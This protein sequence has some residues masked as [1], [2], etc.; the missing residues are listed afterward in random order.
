MSDIQN[1]FTAYL[2]RAIHNGKCNYMQKINHLNRRIIL[3]NAVRMEESLA[4]E[5][6]ARRQAVFK[7]IRTG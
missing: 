6:S 1:R 4:D 7:G 2:L 5:G 3:M